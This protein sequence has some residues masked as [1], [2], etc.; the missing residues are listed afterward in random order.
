[1]ATEEVF[2]VEDDA[3]LRLYLEEVLGGAGYKVK[4]F[5]SAEE[6]LAAISGKTSALVTDLRLPEMSGAELIGEIKRRNIRLGTV[7][8]TAYATEDI[9][10]ELASKGIELILA[11]PFTNTELLAAVDDALHDT[12]RLHGEEQAGVFEET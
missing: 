8:I 4:A 3:S 10:V 7:L 6:G 11:K 5:A 1:M 12:R 9:T 2:V